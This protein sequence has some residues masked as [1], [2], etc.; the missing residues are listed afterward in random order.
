M[1]SLLRDAYEKKLNI[2]RHISCL[3]AEFKDT[4]IRLALQEERFALEIRNRE[5][6][7][8]K[9]KRLEEEVEALHSLLQEKDKQ[10]QTVASSNAQNFME[11]DKLRQRSAPTQSTT[12]ALS[13]GDPRFIKC[14]EK[15]LFGFLLEKIENIHYTLK[16]KEREV[17]TLRKKFR[18]LS[19]YWRCKIKD[20]ETKLETNRNEDEG[21]KKK[22]LKLE[23]FLH[24]SQS[25]LLALQKIEAKRDETVKELAQTISSMQHNRDSNIISINGIWNAACTKCAIYVSVTVIIYFVLSRK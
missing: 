16:A 9:T 17:V 10:L 12:E 22:V 18:M 6:A 15:N 2:R 14:I 8:K 13:T 4:Q 5:E 25:Q 21:L 23:V 20:L 24:Q 19:A 1:D 7:E 3:M 11:L